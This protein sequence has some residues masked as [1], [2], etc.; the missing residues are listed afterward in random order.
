[1]GYTA[2]EIRF[3]TASLL[4]PCRGVA[5]LRAGLQ[6]AEMV[7][8]T[9]AGEF[10]GNDMVLVIGEHVEPS[11]SSVVIKFSVFSGIIHR[12]NGGAI[13]VNDPACVV[14]IR[15]DAFF[16]C[17]AGSV[18]EFYRGGCAALENVT[19]GTSVFD[20]CARKCGCYAGSFCVVRVCGGR[21][22][23]RAVSVRLPESGRRLPRQFCASGSV[24]V[25]LHK[26]D[27]E[28]G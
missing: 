23:E 24:G 28:V 4:P 6:R 26:A 21:R 25:E 13:F 7:L 9:D 16:N 18:G 20:S 14:S 17:T 11:G 3:N 22:V 2:I 27:G 10:P 15:S 1:V 8:P 12:D 19:S 5:G